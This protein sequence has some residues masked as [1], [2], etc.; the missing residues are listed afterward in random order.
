MQTIPYVK[1]CRKRVEELM[2]LDKSGQG[3][4]EYITKSV[5]HLI[6]INTNPTLPTY[7]R[8]CRLAKRLKLSVK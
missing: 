4:V 1:E 7:Q 2:L 8:M 5:K 6:N 3:N